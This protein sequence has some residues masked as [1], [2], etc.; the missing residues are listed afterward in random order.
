MKIE[1]FLGPQ[2]ANADRGFFILDDGHYAVVFYGENQYA[3]ASPQK[4]GEVYHIWGRDD[5][6][7]DPKKR[8]LA[9]K[10]ISDPKNRVGDDPCERIRKNLER[11]LEF[12]RDEP[13]PG[14]AQETFDRDR[15]NFYRWI[16]CTKENIEFF[17]SM[18]K[19]IGVP[20]LE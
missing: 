11:T 8:Q 17:N 3:Y 9:Q 2:R 4:I 13:N 12:Y 5:K 6:E 15:Q 1:K 19:E 14:D 10:I 7:L 18:M 16:L 20:V